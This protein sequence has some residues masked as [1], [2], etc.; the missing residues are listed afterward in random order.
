MAALEEQLANDLKEAM[1]AG[2]TVRRDVIRYLRAA[3]KN[4]LIARVQVS[5]YPATEDEDGLPIEGAAD[6]VTRAPERDEPLSEEEELAV[7]QAQIKQRQ[8]AIEQFQRAGRTDLVER[9]NAQLAI[10]RPYLPAGLSEREIDAL[11]REVIAE[12]GATGPR[13]MKLVMPALIARAGGRA[14]NRTLSEAAR[15]ALGAG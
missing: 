2:D 11:V 5:E 15:R 6:S 8:D 10:L 13:D 7:L 1:R 9:E 3:L 12:T 14:D 4:A